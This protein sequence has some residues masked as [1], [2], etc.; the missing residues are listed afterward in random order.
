MHL[1]FLSELSKLCA[2]YAADKWLASTI[3]KI[4]QGLVT[5]YPSLSLVNWQ[6]RYLC[7]VAIKENLIEKWMF[8]WILTLPAK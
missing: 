5:N 3:L 4:R 6:V 7:S 2:I 1:P 8:S